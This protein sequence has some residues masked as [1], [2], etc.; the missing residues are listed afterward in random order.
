MIVF[1]RLVLFLLLSLLAPVTWAQQKGQSRSGNDKEGRSLDLLIL[2]DGAVVNGTVTLFSE[3][4][5]RYIDAAGTKLELPTE[6]VL[7]L[8]IADEDRLEQLQIS[9]ALFKAKY[10]TEQDYLL[11]KNGTRLLCSLEA[12]DSYFFHIRRYDAYDSLSRVPH[13]SVHVFNS[14][15]PLAQQ[16]VKEF[17]N[18]ERLFA[19]L[20]ESDGGYKRARSGGNWNADYLVKKDGT[21]ERVIIT[22]G[23]STVVYAKPAF[24]TYGNQTAVAYPQQDI[25]ALD[26]VSEPDP[27]HIKPWQ[28]QLDRKREPTISVVF[29][30]RLTGNVQFLPTQLDQDLATARR[31]SQ[32]LFLKGGG[33]MALGIGGF[34]V[35]Y[36]QTFGALSRNEDGRAIAGIGGMAASGV[37]IGWATNTLWD[38]TLNYRNYRKL[39][40]LNN[41]IKSLQVRPTGLGLSLLMGL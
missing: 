39:V 26:F 3:A 12:V 4:L 2:A 20:Q 36:G 7:S 29:A 22:G 17:S 13:D 25:I 19:P 9:P 18:L 6:R 21:V 33:L 11:L 23:D 24:F 8:L 1:R 37:V 30:R 10:Y 34:L 35:S 15:K 38:A 16:A 40:R 41:S 32:G 5:T 28:K 14:Q 27:F 31:F